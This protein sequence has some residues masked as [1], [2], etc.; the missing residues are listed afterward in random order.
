MSHTESRRR[1]EDALRYRLKGWSYQEI[2]DELGFQHREGARRAVTRLLAETCRPS[3]DEAQ[4]ESAESL[5][6][7]RRGLFGHLEV[8]NAE[9][10]AE[11]ATKV[12]REIRA[13]LDSA[14]VREGLNAA[15]RTEVDVR[16]DPGAVVG[17]FFKA[18]L[19]GERP[20]VPRL[21]SQVPIEAEV[22]E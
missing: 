8:A 1:G 4:V 20:A 9:G 11:T 5:R 18:L 2:A 13:N 12:A 15:A 17:D 21:V 14:A 6:L 10:D 16:L 22:I 7:V 19:A 3:V